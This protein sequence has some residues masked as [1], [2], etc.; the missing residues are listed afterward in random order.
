[1]RKFQ[2]WYPQ[3]QQKRENIIV[4][5]VSL[6]ENNRHITFV[7]KKIISAAMTTCKYH[8]ELLQQIFNILAEKYVSTI[9]KE[10]VIISLFVLKCIAINILSKVKE[11]QSRV[12]IVG[13][14]INSVRGVFN[15]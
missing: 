5:D 8:F 2:K 12:L 15:I 10:L 9:Q 13:Y 11:K 4:I 3:Q 6:P 14:T 1:M 7:R